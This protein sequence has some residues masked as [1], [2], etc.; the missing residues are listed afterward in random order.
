[1]AKIEVSLS[2]DDIETI[3]TIIVAK[4]RENKVDRE[5]TYTVKEV[6][7]ITKKSPQTIHI[8]IKRGLLKASRIGRE[9]IITQKGLDDYINPTKKT[10]ILK[11]LNR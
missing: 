3:A 4:L 6:A 1:M 7:E 2:K 10:E 5:T 11:L 9:Y 8:H